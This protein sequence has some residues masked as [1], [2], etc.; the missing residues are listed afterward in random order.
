[1]LTDNPTCSDWV[2]WSSAL[3]N[4]IASYVVEYAYFVIFGVAFAGTAAILVETLS[5]HATGTGLGIEFDLIW[6]IYG[7]TFRH[8][9]SSGVA[10]WIFDSWILQHVGIGC[11]G[12]CSR[13]CCGLRTDVGQRRAVSTHIMLHWCHVL[14]VFKTVCIIFEFTLNYDRPNSDVI[15]FITMIGT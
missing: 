2:T 11:Q 14:Q 12:D 3:S 10:E 9:G 1:M 5:K 7:C 13:A 15:Y 6:V 4:P 8:S